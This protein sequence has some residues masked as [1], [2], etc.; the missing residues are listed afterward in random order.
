MD[1]K[2]LW[3]KLSQT[4]PVKTW[5]EVK[6]FP[7]TPQYL[8]FE[9]SSRKFYGNL[10]NYT[11]AKLVIGGNNCGFDDDQQ[12]CELKP[13]TD[14]ELMIRLCTDETFADSDLMP[15]RTN[16]VIVHI[17]FVLLTSVAVLLLVLLVCVG[18]L[19]FYRDKIT[20]LWFV[21]Y[22]LTK[23]SP[24]TSYLIINR[25]GKQAQ[26]IKSTKDTCSD[27]FPVLF[28]SMTGNENAKILEEFRAIVEHSSNLNL[29]STAAIRHK[30][31]NR[32]DNI[33]PFDYNRVVLD[34]E[35]KNDYINASYIDVSFLK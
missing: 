10:Q 22:H 35:F 18:F 2:P 16:K 15:F 31:R 33:H 32:Y 23:L 5:S 29:T 19:I 11:K 26:S 9:L 4:K 21:V 34:D 28:A 14:Y 24:L 3:G 27:N 17:N 12:S 30:Q 7:C 13:E 25:H 6:N 1:F 8:A 20:H